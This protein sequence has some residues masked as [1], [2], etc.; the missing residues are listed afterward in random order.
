MEPGW[1]L[2]GKDKGLGAGGECEVWAQLTWKIQGRT[3]ECAHAM[4]SRSRKAIDP[5]ITTMP[6]RSTPGF[7][8]TRQTLRAPSA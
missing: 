6:G 5:R 1:T 3:G 8:Q 2:Q 7:H 4:H